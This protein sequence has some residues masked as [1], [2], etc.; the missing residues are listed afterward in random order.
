MCR[1]DNVNT[2]NRLIANE[3]FATVQDIAE[4]ETDSDVDNMAKRM[5]NRPAAT[6]LPQRV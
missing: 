2:Q 6:R 3:G 4:L 1:I 5:A